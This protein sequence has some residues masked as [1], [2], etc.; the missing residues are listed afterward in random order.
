MRAR[1]EVI[2]SGRVQGVGFRWHTAQK[3]RALGLLGWVRN[4]PDGTVR[5]VAEGPRR[6]AESLLAW[7]HDGPDRAQV[8]H[9]EAVWREP[10]DEFDHFNVSG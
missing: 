1:L 8:D 6:S 9:C 2:V 10:T 4:L 3:A 7:L 5:V